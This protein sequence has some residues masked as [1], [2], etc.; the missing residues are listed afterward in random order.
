MNSQV[1]ET[2]AEAKPWPVFSSLRASI[3]PDWLTKSIDEISAVYGDQINQISVYLWHNET[4]DHKYPITKMGDIHIAWKDHEKKPSEDDLDHLPAMRRTSRLAAELFHDIPISYSEDDGSLNGELSFFFDPEGL[5]FNWDEEYVDGPVYEAKAIPNA[6]DTWHYEERVILH[7]FNV[8]E[9]SLVA[10]NTSNILAQI[11]ASD[12][13]LAK[14]P[15]TELRHEIGENEELIII[16]P[17]GGLF[18]EY[19]GQAT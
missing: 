17:S 9:S 3:A 4:G 18:A 12:V 13:N 1:D 6:D 8:T 14:W 2:L 7:D 15:E 11:H 5:T 16:A 19:E 10:G